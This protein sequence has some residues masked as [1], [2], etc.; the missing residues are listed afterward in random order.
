MAKSPDALVVVD[1]VVVTGSA[2]LDHMYQKRPVTK[3]EIFLRCAHSIAWMLLYVQ[4]ESRFMHS[5]KHTNWL[6]M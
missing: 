2:K 3:N 4:Q 5:Y 6:S 1:A